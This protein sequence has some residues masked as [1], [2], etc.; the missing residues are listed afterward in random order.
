VLPPEITERFASRRANLPQGAKILYKPALLGQAKVHYAQTTADV[1]CWQD[2][3][4]LLP[5]E[6]PLPAEL[7]STVEEELESPPDLENQPE[8]GAGFAELPGELS[9]P[10][11]YDELESSLKDFIYR[12]RKLSL[13]K[14][15]ALKQTSAP[16]ET[17]AEFRI[18][19]GQLARESRDEQ[20]EKLRQKYG[21]KIATIEERIR[22]AEMKVEK[23]KAQAQEKTWSAF[24]S[25]GTSVLSML[26]G[27]KM[28]S[29]TNVSRAATA[30]RAGS[31]VF[32]ERQDISDA[33]ED[34][35]A[36]QQQ[37]SALEAEAQAETTKVQ[38]G[39]QPDSLVL[40][41]VQIAPKKSEIN[42][43]GV[44]LVWQPWIVRMDR[45]AE[46]SC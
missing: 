45:V 19:L 3:A 17:E 10:K 23:E 9:R 39:L 30:A 16:G 26:M 22:K 46:L 15:K 4:L 43:T 28:M 27:R 14:C 20:V 33:T 2:V 42:V 12:N 36:L 37:L 5:V 44:T 35:A 6:G 8:A 38:D 31:R 25:A 11:R 29:T 40:D 13:W 1:D 41:E 18:R 24:L 7:W 21:A 34:V 32:R